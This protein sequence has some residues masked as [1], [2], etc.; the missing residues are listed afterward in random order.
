MVI[1][2]W[3]ANYAG[4]VYGLWFF[5]PDELSNFCR[6]LNSFVKIG[7]ESELERRA[8]S[9]TQ[10]LEQAV[11]VKVSKDTF[12]KTVQHTSPVKMVEIFRAMDERG[13]GKI[14]GGPNDFVDLLSESLKVFRVARWLILG[15]SCPV[16][17]HAS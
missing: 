4:T 10:L 15:W 8:P 11:Q 17:S 12:D 2:E 16:H 13:A 6:A 9:V 7:P 5:S 1:L 3:V 14:P